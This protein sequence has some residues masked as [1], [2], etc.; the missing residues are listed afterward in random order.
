MSRSSYYA[1]PA[2]LA[3]RDA[4]AIAALWQVHEAHPFYGVT[5]FAM[6]FGWSEDKA[7]RIRNLAGIH[8]PLAG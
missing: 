1:P 2:V 3:D 8:V 7:R 4:Q 5:R 6:H